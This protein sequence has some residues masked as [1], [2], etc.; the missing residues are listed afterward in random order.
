MAGVS[1]PHVYIVFGE[2][3]PV[4]ELTIGFT[5]SDSSCTTT[6]C[7]FLGGGKFNW[8]SVQYQLGIS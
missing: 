4:D 1:N 6:G 7:P 2:M 8:A 3:G 5:L